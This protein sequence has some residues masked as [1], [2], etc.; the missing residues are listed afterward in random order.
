MYCQTFIPHV[1]FPRQ[2]IINNRHVSAT[3]LEN[4]TEPLLSKHNK[5]S[6]GDKAIWD[7]A[8]GEEIGGLI[9]LPCW[10]TITASEYHKLQPLIGNAIPTMAISTIKSDENGQPK[11]AKYRIVAL[12]NLDPH[13][14]SKSE[15]NA[16]VMSHIESRLLNSIAVH[17]R[18][19]TKSGD[20]K[21][22]FVQSCLPPNERYVLRPPP[23]CT[24]S[25][26]NTFWLL[27]RS[28]YGLK[29]NPRHW[30]NK[31]KTILQSMNLQPCPNL[32]CIF[33]GRITKDSAPIYIGFYVD[34]FIYFSEDDETKRLF[35]KLLKSKLTVDFMGQTS[36]F[37]GMKYTWVQHNDGHVTL[38]LSQP[39]FI[40]QLLATINLLHPHVNTA[41]TPYR[42]GLPVDSILPTTVSESQQT[43][44]QSIY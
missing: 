29:R 27:I 44:L 6:P 16:P 36:H 12:G 30:Y 41:S 19:T 26:S 14:W 8:Y 31:F 38:H 11:Q 35:K 23:G 21:Q 4:L 10:R 42:S 3:D 37:L 28:I 25:P 13:P 18:R 39:A 32:P 1:H 43:A 20:V 2:H 15:V 5:L 40:E 9:N 34:D 33:T 22:A 24:H 17:M 7:A